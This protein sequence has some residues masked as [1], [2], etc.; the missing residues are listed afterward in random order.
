M[1]NIP[2]PAM[3]IDRYAAP[4]LR[5]RTIRSG[6]SGAGALVCHYANTASSATPAAMNPQVD[7]VCQLCVAALEKP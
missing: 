1:P 7:G 2:L 6:S 5:S 3:R 4:R